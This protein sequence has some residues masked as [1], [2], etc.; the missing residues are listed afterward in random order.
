[1]NERTVSRIEGWDSRPYTG[2]YASL[3][4]FADGGFTGAVRT[5]GTWLFMLNGRVV[6]VHGGTIEDFEG[7][8]GTAY[9][10]P[11]PS[12]PLLFTMLEEGGEQRAKYYTNDTPI[13][14]AHQ[15]LSD[16][17]FT[18]Y[19]ELS[20]NVLS[21]DYYVLYYGGRSMSCAFV[22]NSERLEAGDEAFALADD[23]VGIYEVRT[24]DI[25]VVD[26]PEPTSA[27]E[28][29]SAAAAGTGG[30]E[31]ASDAP[32]AA[33]D[34]DA[35]G[36][37]SDLDA[38]DAA[39]DPDAPGASSGSDAPGSEAGPD[40]TDSGL[41]PEP[42]EPEGGS[43]PTAGAGETADAPERSAAGA[44]DV[45]TETVGTPG[46]GRTDDAAPETTREASQS[47]T[48]D[49]GT[50]EAVEPSQPESSQS[51]PSH[52]TQPEPTHSESAQPEPTHS[53]SAHPEPTHSE[54][55]QPEPAHPESAQPSQP[56][57]SQPEP[58]HSESA[59][60]EPAQSEP[61]QPEPARAET[62]STAEPTGAVDSRAERSTPS[63]RTSSA[64]T[65][66]GSATDHAVLKSRVGDIELR[67]IP[68][69]SPDHT[70][71]AEP[72]SEAAAEESAGGSD[73][74][75]VSTGASSDVRGGVGGRAGPN[76][77][78]GSGSEAG[79][80]PGAASVS[81]GTARRSSGTADAGT[82]ATSGTE[83]SD[84]G[85]VP[86]D[87]DELRHELQAREER[88]GELEAA[89]ADL[90]VQ[91]DGLTDERDRLQSEVGRLESEVDELEEEIDRLR[92]RLNQGSEGKKRLSPEQALE[93]TNLFVRYGSKSGGTLE[94]AHAGEVE[95]EE[96]NENLRIEHHTQFDA[97]GVVIDGDDFGTYLSDSIYL[98]FVEWIVRD[99]LYEIRD[100]GHVKALSEL[101]DAIPRIDRAELLGEVSVQFSED[102]EQYREQRS[103]DV[104]LRDRMGNPLI[105]ANLNDSRNPADNEMMKTILTQAG[106][107]K[108]SN[109]TL[110]SAMMVTSS[111]FQ[112]G[113]L[114]AAEEAVGSGILSRD[115][116]KSY[117]KTARK[118]G[119][120]LILVESRGGEFHV[121]VPEL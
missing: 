98:T 32:G 19:I 76:G 12:L 55:A 95:R 86:D 24:V 61:S 94:N 1:M 13:S 114:E 74:F 82:G 119:Y 121:N 73:E 29:R 4:E 23:E 78:A 120:H 2:G 14:E 20:E 5:G 33:S 10:A 110:S 27:S 56:E 87:V 7:A 42:A 57:S 34:L 39:S 16:A 44:G 64:R 50:G 37:A 108:T 60:P 69:L 40:P 77:T 111:F 89:L 62:A 22:G 47:P 36:A 79:T 26:I 38:P 66:S 6:G 97:D 107:V 101:Y 46:A 72:G 68:S 93:G 105:V 17:S 58:A 104:V 9:Q 71:V 45:H 52:P 115:S 91:R 35:P 8:E 53:E 102:G 80:S 3:R 99:L 25:D 63:S 18:G 59:Q 28:D 109:E 85:S 31:A 90:R 92:S 88:I 51:E 30:S 83:I 11:H 54:S 65:E 84:P 96:V 116:K 43:D 113:A 41:A 48:G 117:V 67:T 118:S 100:T 81:A 106:D 112:P 15:Q 70:T 21:G 75:S 103:F 49:A